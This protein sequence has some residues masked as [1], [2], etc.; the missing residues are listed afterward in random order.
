M[1]K[2]LSKTNHLQL[3][4]TAILRLDFNTK[5]E[6]RINTVLPT[7]KFLKKYADKILIISHRGRPNGF[8]KNLSL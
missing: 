3:K 4:G 5:D 8:D 6:W 7:I 1:I 2:F